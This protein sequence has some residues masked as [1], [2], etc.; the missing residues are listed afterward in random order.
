VKHIFPYDNVIAGILVLLVGFVGHWI[1]QGLSVINW[2]LATKLGL[3]EAG[4]PSE[5]KNYE[6]GIAVADVCIGWVY[7][8]AGLGLLIAAPWGY[9]LAGVSG[10]ILVYHALSFW[11]W[12]GNHRRAGYDLATTRHPL[13]GVWTLANL[14]AGG[15]AI[16]LAWTAS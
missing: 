16:L 12:T 5:F 9:K 7:G 4:M 8:L 14:A 1:G 6:H 10:A 15:L 3:Q 13:R 11:A 2:R